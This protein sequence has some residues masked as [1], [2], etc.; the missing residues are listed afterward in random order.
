MGF[1]DPD[2]V[3][4]RQRL[5]RDPAHPRPRSALGQAPLAAGLA[6]I[7]HE[8]L[9]PP[10]RSFPPK[11]SSA[12]LD[13]S[14]GGGPCGPPCPRRAVAVVALPRLDEKSLSRTSCI[15]QILHQCSTH[16]ALSQPPVRVSAGCP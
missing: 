6:R 4:R 13:D 2:R 14:S 7:I 5:R 3:R 16:P 11:A 15:W 8:R 9:R 10:L 12:L 1:E